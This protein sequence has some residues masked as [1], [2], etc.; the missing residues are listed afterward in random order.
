MKLNLLLLFLFIP[1]LLLLIIN[2]NN[3]SFRNPNAND[4]DFLK[5]CFTIDNSFKKYY[6]Y[7]NV[8]T[9]EHSI[10]FLTPCNVIKELPKI[11]NNGI[12]LNNFCVDP[13]KRNKGIGTKLMK[14]VINKVKK[15]GNTHIVLQVLNNN[16]YAIRLYKKFG[17]KKYMEG[18]NDKNEKVS[19]YVLY[20]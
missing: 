1:L 7:S 2:Y 18:Y 20:L 13:N 6:K 8:I 3:E 9:L 16:K 19:I 14:H 17:F 12:F 5:K 11:K 15:D 4:I 10:L